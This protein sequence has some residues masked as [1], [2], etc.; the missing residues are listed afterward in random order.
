[1]ETHLERFL[2]PDI[3]DILHVMYTRSGL[4]GEHDRLVLRFPG[5]TRGVGCCMMEQKWMCVR[6]Y[7]GAD[8]LGTGHG[9]I[10]L[11]ASQLRATQAKI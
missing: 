10:W 6:I 8:M 1:M 11:L 7:H 2:V 9:H 5:K 4:S 3:K